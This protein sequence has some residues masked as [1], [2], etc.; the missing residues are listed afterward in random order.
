MRTILNTIRTGG[1]VRIGRFVIFGYDDNRT[2]SARQD[3]TGLIGPHEKVT[4]AGW[5]RTLAWID[6]TEMEQG[7]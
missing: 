6:Q 5:N 4:A 3:G 2:M 7:R 1:T